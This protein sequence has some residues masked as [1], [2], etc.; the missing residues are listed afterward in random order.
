M[1]L[2]G[3]ASRHLLLDP[4]F[5]R[6][7]L[8]RL[9]SVPRHLALFPRPDL[10]RPGVEVLELRLKAHDGA[11][12][13]A[14]LARS[15]FAANG[16][17]VHLRLAQGC[18]HNGSSSSAA[19]SSAADSPMEDALDWGA[20]ERGETDLVFRYPGPEPRRLEDRVLDALRIVDAACSIESVDCGHIT[21]DDEQGHLPDEFVIAQF[22]RLK[23]WIQPN[24]G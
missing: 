11:R 18:G 20:V 7:R 9:A 2:S 3:D 13:K 10:E 24:A 1:G 12:L 17:R 6:P 19:H 23:G 16:G 21:F 8:E 15:A 22:F 4:D 14:V 5:W